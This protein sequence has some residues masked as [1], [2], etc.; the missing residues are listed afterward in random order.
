[1]AGPDPKPP[2]RPLLKDWSGAWQ[3]S[4]IGFTLVICSAI[5]SGIGYWVDNRWHTSPMGIAIGF[6]FGTAAGF[7]EM[8]N[9]V[10]KAN[11]DD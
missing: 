6:L 7:L 9:I 4:S 10:K 1:M 2:R 11:K 5:G 3:M 8:F